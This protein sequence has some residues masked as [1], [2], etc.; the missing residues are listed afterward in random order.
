MSLFTDCFEVDQLWIIVIVLN[1]ASLFFCFVL[2]GFK[3]SACSSEEPNKR[4][5]GKRKQG[6]YFHR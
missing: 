5:K 6:Y 4:A 3:I 1:S 2:T